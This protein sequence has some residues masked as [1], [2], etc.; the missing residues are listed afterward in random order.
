MRRY[1]QPQA[2]YLKLEFA[3]A[4]GK[5]YVIRESLDYGKATT[6]VTWGDGKEQPMLALSKPL[7]MLRLEPVVNSQPYDE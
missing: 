3:D 4:D 7:T 6:S 1:T 2:T 5:T